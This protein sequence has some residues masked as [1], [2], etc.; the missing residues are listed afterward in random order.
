M[1]VNLSRAISYGLVSAGTA[2]IVKEDLTVFLTL[3]ISIAIIW[4][5]GELVD[6]MY[7]HITSRAKEKPSKSDGLKP[8]RLSEAERH[9]TA[10]HE[11][12]HLVVGGAVGMADVLE[13]ASIIPSPGCRGHVVRSNEGETLNL[14]KQ[15]YR[16]Q[17]A[18]LLGGRVAEELVLGGADSGSGE[19]LRQ[20]SIYVNDML[21]SAGLGEGELAYLYLD[22]DEIISQELRV[23]LEKAKR[24]EI[25]TQAARAKTIL[26]A[27]RALLDEIAAKLVEVGKLEGAELT[28][29][30]CKIQL[31]S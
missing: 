30:L 28:L 11:A 25:Q 21:E 12:G 29:L 5:V 24:T 1:N 16:D 31:P 14:T 19:D 15:G 7:E 22:G 27:N 20:A 3:P 8:R 17:I 6:W 4:A 13:S 2:A 9:R 10:V 18:F 26:E 23:M